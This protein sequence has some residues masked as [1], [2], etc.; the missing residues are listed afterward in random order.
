MGKEKKENG[1]SPEEPRG[2]GVLGGEAELGPRCGGR[3]GLPPLPGVQSVYILLWR[4]L[5][6]KHS[7]QPR[8]AAAGK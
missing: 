7:L 2:F 1:I 3:M 4:G 6:F 5:L 8:D